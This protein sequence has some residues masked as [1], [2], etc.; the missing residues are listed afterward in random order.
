MAK[1]WV[2]PGIGGSF[3]YGAR[4][5]ANGT[6]GPSIKLWLDLATIVNPDVLNRLT[7]P[8]ASGFV[9]F[10]GG[11]VNSIMGYGYGNLLAHLDRTKPAGWKV[12]GYGYD[13]RQSAVDCGLKLAQTIRDDPD[14]AA[15]NKLIAHSF[16]GLVAMEAFK[17]LIGMGLSSKVSRIVFVGTP[18]Y[19][20]HCAPRVFAE[21][22]DGIIQLASARAITA[23]LL[24]A[25]FNS[26]LGSRTFTS[27][28]ILNTLRTWPSLYDLFPEPAAGDDPPDSLRAAQLYDVAKW[29]PALVL[30]DAAQLARAQAWRAGLE[31]TR[32]MLG[33]KVPICVVGLHEK[34]PWRV[35]ATEGIP[36]NAF[37]GFILAN[38][39]RAEVVRQ[40]M[41]PQWSETTLGDGRVTL[42]SQYLTGTQQWTI[43][44]SHSE[45]QSH[46]A[47]WAAAWDLLQ[48]QDPQ[49]GPQG[50]LAQDAGDWPLQTRA[51]NRPAMGT[52]PR[53]PPTAQELEMARA[54]AAWKRRFEG[55]TEKQLSLARGI[56]G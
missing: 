34:T 8:D 17:Q 11:I 19:G 13:W 28:L 47:L 41:L 53:R 18:F 42:G 35:S 29:G 14:Q 54:G 56:G 51:V 49:P 37:Q 38:T 24:G 2:I 33:T 46:R 40:A 20:T 25:G 50:D 43:N 6:R 1:V 32:A 10:A 55:R 27:S 30:P 3:L 48:V 21:Y 4:L 16:G 9:S 15:D 44:G 7:L 52:G 23:L 39:G 12:A 45:Q 22:E 36:V 5:L 31:T 26:A